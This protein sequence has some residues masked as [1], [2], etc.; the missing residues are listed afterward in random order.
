MVGICS[1]TSS[2]L[3]RRRRIIVSCCPHSSSWKL[4]C[5]KGFK[6]D[7]YDIKSISIIFLQAVSNV[8]WKYIYKGR[9]PK[10]AVKSLVFWQTRGGSMVTFSWNTYLSDMYRLTPRS[11]EFSCGCWFQFCHE[12]SC[13]PY[14]TGQIIPIIVET[15]SIQALRLIWDL[16]WI[17][18]KHDT[19]LTL[20]IENIENIENGVRN[21]NEIMRYNKKSSDWRLSAGNTFQSRCWKIKMRLNVLLMTDDSRKERGRG[22][23]RDGGRAVKRAGGL[24]SIGDLRTQLNPQ[25]T[26]CCWHLTTGSFGKTL[27]LL[28]H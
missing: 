18:V 2:L 11:R 17:N 12:L 27:T 3:R 28:G 6:L 5:S 7:F 20:N 24:C 13:L 10:N 14:C 8:L 16:K 25:I 21:N 22:V 1:I 26:H 15:H 9:V 4:K 23:K 19:I